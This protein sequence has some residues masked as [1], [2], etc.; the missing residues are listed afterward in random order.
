MSQHN[1]NPTVLLR[2]DREVALIKQELTH[3]SLPFLYTLAPPGKNG[4]RIE[5]FNLNDLPEPLSFASYLSMLRQVSPDTLA[6]ARL[7]DTAFSAL[8]YNYLWTD[9]CSMEFGTWLGQPLIY[10]VTTT[11]FRKFRASLPWLSTEC[12]ENGSID[13]ICAEVLFALFYI[14]DDVLDR[15]NH[16]YGR[17]TSYGCF[18]ERT[19]ASWNAAHK[20][21]GIGKNVL[22]CDKDRIELWRETLEHIQEAEQIRVSQKEFPSLSEYC[23]QSIRR[24]EFLGLWWDRSVRAC[25]RFNVAELIAAI[26]PLCALA[27]QL[28]NDLR[29]TE[30][31]EFTSGGNPYSDFTDARITAITLATF[32]V[33]GKVDKSWIMQK[34][35]GKGGCTIYMRRRLKQICVESGAINLVRELLVSHIELIQNHVKH[36]NVP[37][38][39]KKLWLGWVHRQFCSSVTV[40][41]SDTSPDSTAFIKAI[42]NLSK[43]T[44]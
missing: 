12:D 7:V 27:G 19:L 40:R 5:W 29:N 22:G 10:T 39:V 31:R 4:R 15:K 8:F 28:R 36:S 37:S 43:S 11:P 13:S 41:W 16:R 34:V 32:N 6:Y 23:Q 42:G 18:G 21:E 3:P 24:T 33:V 20:I 44:V 2:G 26:Y 17:R 30:N 14:Y 38:S 35:W 9:R 25:Y 1:T